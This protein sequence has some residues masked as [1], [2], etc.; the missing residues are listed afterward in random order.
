ML[1]KENNLQGKV[2]AQTDGYRLQPRHLFIL[3]KLPCEL[4]HDCIELFP[5]FIK[6]PCLQI[7]ELYQAARMDAPHERKCI[8]LVVSSRHCGP[9]ANTTEYI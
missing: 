9:E 3:P 4:L 8:A 5:K 7:S 6:L 1:L 2:R